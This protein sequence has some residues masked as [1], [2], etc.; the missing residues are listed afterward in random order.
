[1]VDELDQMAVPLAE[2]KLVRFLHSCKKI[3]L[4]LL[5]FVLTVSIARSVKIFFDKW[6]ELA[7]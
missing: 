2:K 4:L 1:M 5:K 7:Y 3:S 6:N